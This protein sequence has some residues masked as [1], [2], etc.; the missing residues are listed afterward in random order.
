M[1]ST[2][3]NRAVAQMLADRKVRTLDMGGDVL[4]AASG[5][6]GHPCIP[7]APH[8]RGLAGGRTLTGQARLNMAEIQ[9][10]VTSRCRGVAE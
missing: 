3:V 5:R 9:G 1:L 2:R 4:D 7:D 6:R 8:S 10:G